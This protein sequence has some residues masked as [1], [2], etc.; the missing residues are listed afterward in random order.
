MV[1]YFFDQK[2]HLYRLLCSILSKWTTM[3]QHRSRGEE[4]LGNLNTG[5]LLPKMSWIMKKVCE[6]LCAFVRS[7]FLMTLYIYLFQ[8]H[9][10][11]IVMYV[12]EATNKAIQSNRVKAQLYIQELVRC[13]VFKWC[14][15]FLF[16]DMRYGL[17]VSNLSM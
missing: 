15:C 10:G 13:S 2:L 17:P 9:Q 7:G 8:G 12:F 3:Q 1:V 4:P 6:G 16:Y 14:L 5:I 11:H